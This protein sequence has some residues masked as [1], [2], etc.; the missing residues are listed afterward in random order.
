MDADRPPTGHEMPI[1]VGCSSCRALYAEVCELRQ[2]LREAEER[3]AAPLVTPAAGPGA[4][5]RLLTNTTTKGSTH[6]M[7]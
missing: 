7:G 3:A 5:P 6:E 1:G 4:V 2:R